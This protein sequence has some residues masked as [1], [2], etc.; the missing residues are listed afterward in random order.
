[1][2]QVVDSYTTLHI[3]NQTYAPKTLT[4]DDGTSQEPTLTQDPKIYHSTPTNSSSQHP[5]A[6]QVVDFYTTLQDITVSTATYV[7]FMQS[8][9]TTLVTS[10]ITTQLPTTNV[11][12]MLNMSFTNM[13]FVLPPILQLVNKSEVPPSNIPRKLADVIANLRHFSKAPQ[14]YTKDPKEAIGS[15]AIGS[16][17][18]VLDIAFLAFIIILDFD[19]LIREGR[20]LKRNIVNMV[21][22]FCKR[23]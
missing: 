4:T 14:N 21:N 18:V 16:S 8:K 17:M 11:T 23:E 20:R 10:N 19:A 7:R 13:S 15:P 12:P 22:T 9:E 5:T 2:L 1:M 3:S 6:L